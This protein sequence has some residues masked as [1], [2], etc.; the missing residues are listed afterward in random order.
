MP[1]VASTLLPLE[2]STFSR[3]LCR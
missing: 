2:V 3:C 1:L